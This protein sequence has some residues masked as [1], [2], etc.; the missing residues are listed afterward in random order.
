M[1]DKLTFYRSDNN[2]WR[3]RYQAE[4]N[5]EKMA[6]GGEGYHSLEACM[7]GAY[8]VC[9]I[10]PGRG[11]VGNLAASAGREH[12]RDYYSVYVEIEGGE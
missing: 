7:A 9:G 1:A 8:R 11:D 3:W 6:N 10:R 12:V 5:M 2:E 4:G